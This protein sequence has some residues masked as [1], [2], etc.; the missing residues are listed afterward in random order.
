MKDANESI[1]HDLIRLIEAIKA[2]NRSGAA[3]ILRKAAAVYKAAAASSR[4]AGLSSESS[5]LLVNNISRALGEAQPGMAG[6]LNMTRQVENALQPSI[7]IEPLD[8]GASA[9]SE[10]AES[11]SRE[12]AASAV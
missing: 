6:L 2:D 12:A 11:A 9:A 5:L 3:E 7:D 8:V 10:F 1:T 4:Q